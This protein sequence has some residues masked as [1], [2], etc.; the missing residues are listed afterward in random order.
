[1]G[2]KQIESANSVET[3][4]KSLESW[5]LAVDRLSQIPNGTYAHGEAQKLLPEYLKK[6]DEVRDR[7]AQEI[8]AT[9][10]LDQV[11][12]IAMA[13]QKAETEE[14]WTISLQKWKTAFSQLQTIPPKTLAHSES[15][16]L[17]GRYATALNKAENNL[18]VALR[19]QPIEPNFFTACGVAGTQKCT[20]SIKSGSVR[21]NLAQG[22][23]TVID[24]SITPPNERSGESPALA[25]VAQANQLLQEITLLSTQAKVPVELYDAQG[26][27]LALY[28]PDLS[29]FTRQT[30]QAAAPAQQVATPVQQANAAQ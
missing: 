28:R 22:Y 17:Q 4:E 19:F 12:Q 11:K 6:L 15:Q 18:Q 26:K 14:Q 24:H 5:E 10:L 3:W 29:G 9:Q 16:T 7:A 25:L 2:T 27:F 21:L 23:D 8:G 20:Y 1:L 30:Q 13:A